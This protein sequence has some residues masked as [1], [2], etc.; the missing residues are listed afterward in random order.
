MSNCCFKFDYDLCDCINLNLNNL[1][2]YSSTC[3]RDIIRVGVRVVDRWYVQTNDKAQQH[4]KYHK[5]W[6]QD[7]FSRNTPDIRPLPMMWIRIDCMQIW[8]HK[9][10]WIRNRIKYGSRLIKSTDWYQTIFQKL[11]KNLFPNLY[12]K[13]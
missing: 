10:W 4:H 2:I 1:F 6:K 11:R 5:S 7:L 13:G 3:V 12:L 9:I 8:I